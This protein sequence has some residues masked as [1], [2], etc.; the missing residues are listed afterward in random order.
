VNAIEFIVIGYA[1]I[2][3]ANRT[4]YM[5]HS[6]PDVVFTPT[7]C[8][9]TIHPSPEAVTWMD[10]ATNY[11]T[12][13]G[14]SDDQLVDYRCEVDDLFEERLWGFDSIFSSLNAIKAFRD[15]W[16]KSKR[17]VKLIEIAIP[18][19]R[20]ADFRKA[21]APPESN[22][23]HNGTHFAS[24]V[25]EMNALNLHV[26]YEIIGVSA[27]NEIH[28]SVCYDVREDFVRD[29]SAT[30]NQS[31]FFDSFEIADLA[32]EKNNNMNGSPVGDVYWFPV[33][34]SIMASD[35]F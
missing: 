6:V 33:R 31:G 8:V 9:C 7:T 2:E 18:E 11:L 5:H 35:I 26:G 23:A 16:F 4:E 29:L 13:L 25:L 34:I 24:I 28:T 21:V 30:F 1:L 20:L 27:W 17:N 32:A 3:G 10:N 22:A 19:Q 15:K 12:N 14:F